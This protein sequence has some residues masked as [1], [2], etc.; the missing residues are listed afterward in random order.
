MLLEEDP[1]KVLIYKPLTGH[2]DIDS[3]P[4]SEDLF[5]LAIQSEEQR[6]L[7]LQEASTILIV[8]ET[9][10]TNQYGFKLLTCLVA[11][12]NNS[13]WPVAHLITSRSD[14]ATLKYFFY[15][16]QEKCPELMINCVITDDDDALINS[17]NFGLNK[18]VRHILCKWHLDK[19]W[20]SRIKELAPKEVTEDLYVCLKLIAETKNKIEFES[21]LAAFK[22]KFKETAPKFLNYFQNEYLQSQ[23]R[24]E[25]WASCFRNFAHGHIE[26]I[27]HIESFH[28]RLKTFHL[29]RKPNKRLDDLVRILLDIENDDYWERKRQGV[30]S[31]N[32]TKKHDERHTK[33]LQILFWATL[34]WEVIVSWKI[35]S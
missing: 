26:T 23:E 20:K 17:I 25:K 3:L 11:D 1:N 10:N 33:G 28:N 30:L 34:V 14:A 31:I 4:K 2:S 24:K 8:D 13:G 16:L 19:I 29:K 5:M 12:S 27:G 22:L 6:E 35:C 21:L 15:S 9:H 7:M 32:K 18:N